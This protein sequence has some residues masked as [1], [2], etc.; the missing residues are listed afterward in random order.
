M[1]D[2]IL[3][4]HSALYRQRLR[5]EVTQAL[6]PKI[7]DSTELL[8]LDTARMVVRI[9]P[10]SKVQ[11]IKILKTAFNTNLWFAKNLWEVA[12]TLES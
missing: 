4:I 11:G 8:Q 3:K 12:E 5:R 7:N 1:L 10:N 2:L 9:A 6:L